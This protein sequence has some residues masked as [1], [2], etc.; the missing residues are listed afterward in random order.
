MPTTI[1]KTIGF[2]SGGT[3]KDTFVTTTAVRTTLSSRIMVTT[4]NKIQINSTKKTWQGNRGLGA[5]TADEIKEIEKLKNLHNPETSAEAKCDK[6]VGVV[7]RGWSPSKRLGNTLYF[8]ANA[9]ITAQDMGVAVE[10]REPGTRYYD[11]AIFCPDALCV[12]GTLVHVDM[13]I[14]QNFEMRCRRIS[15]HI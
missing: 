7:A 4:T 6:P 13:A 15:S 10:L 1:L 14:S 11:T 9:I 12:Q 5:L 8:L 3:G 2:N